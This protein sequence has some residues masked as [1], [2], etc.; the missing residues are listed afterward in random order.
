MNTLTPLQRISIIWHICKKN[1]SPIDR[2]ADYCHL[3][4]E[5]KRLKPN[6]CNLKHHVAKFI[7]LLFHNL[8]SYDCHLLVREL[9]SVE[10]DISIIHLNKELYVTVL[11]KIRVDN[12]NAIKLRFLDSCHFMPSSL[13]KLAGYLSNNGLVTVKSIYQT[14]I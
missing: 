7:P 9:S 2:L 13:W 14:S 11:K 10:G 8:S 1:V 5:F 12:G 6:K 3:T 4:D